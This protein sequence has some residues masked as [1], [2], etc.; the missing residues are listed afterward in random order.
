MRAGIVCHWFNRGQAVVGRHLRSLLADL[1]HETRVLAKPTKPGFHRP[2]YIERGDVWDQ[3][4]VT[5]APA[6][7][8]PWETYR[9]WAAEHEL[10]VIFFDQNYQF[11]EIGRLRAQGIRT[12][13]RFVWEAFEPEHAGAAREAYDT[14]Y[15]LTRCE[16][17][18]YASLGIDSPVVRWGVHPEL[19][20][21]ERPQRD[22]DGVTFFFPGGYLSRRK[23]LA[24]AVRAFGSVRDPALRL[25]I[26]TQGL[27]AGAAPAAEIAAGDPRACVVDGDLPTDEHRRLFAAADVC[28]APSRWEG[29]G[30]HLY[31]ATAFGIPIITNDSPPMNEVVV[32]DDNG[33]LVPS[34]PDG[35]TPSGVP[36]VDPD[37]P[38]LGAAIA[39][40]ADPATRS[41]LAAGADRMARRLDWRHT[42]ADV[43]GLLA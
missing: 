41:R 25:V 21:V 42:T 18:R 20:A 23:P 37:V 2:S 4:G 10:E 1:G 43:R 19:L 34:H 35:V 12:I 28:L 29:L 24:E 39:R 3:P 38:A 5:E 30:L 6:F 27:H 15:S 17:V 9:A 31:E 32:D 11:E 36:A 26:K 13:G 7:W 22:G 33:L 40:L 8:I 16:Q 14:I